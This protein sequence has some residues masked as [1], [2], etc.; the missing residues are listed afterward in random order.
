[1]TDTTPDAGQP[2][3][4]AYMPLDDVPPALDNPKNHD[5]DGLRAS[6]E[7]LG[8]ADAGI[9]DE[10]TGRLIGG[11]GRTEALMEMRSEHR[12]PPEGIT[13]D[14]HGAWLVPIQRGWASRNDAE[15]RALLIAVNRLPEKGGWD[16]AGRARMLEGL[17]AER[18]Q[19]LAAT[20]YA[21]PD[22]DQ[23]LADLA[24]PDAGLS[25]SSAASD[26][27]HHARNGRYEP[28]GWDQDHGSTIRDSRIHNVPPPAPRPTLADRFLIPPF[29]VFDT[30]QDWWQ[31]R[32][33]RWKGLG[34]RS[35]LGRPARD[36][37]AGA[38]YDRDQEQGLAFKSPN[39]RDPTYYQQKSDA[40]AILGR[41]LSNEEFEAAHYVPSNKMPAGTSVFDPVLCELFTRWFTPPGGH[42]LDPFAGG[43]VRGLVAAL[44]GR[45]YTGWDLRQDQVDANE[46][47]AREF[48]ARGLL[49]APHVPRWHQGDSARV[50]GDLEPGTYDAVWTCPPYLWL[51]K[52][53]DDPADLSTMKAD[54]FE[55]AYRLIL[56]GAARALA[57]NRFAGIVVGDVRDPRGG[58]LYDLRGMTIRAA[59]DAGLTY[60]SSATVITHA[61][62]L[63][64]RT[65]RWFEH[66]R[67]LGR[68]TQTLLVFVKGDR[69]AAATACGDVDVTLPDGLT[70]LDT[71]DD[72]NG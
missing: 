27:V 24:R 21:P 13:L 1:M 25:L 43:S 28:D 57:P 23:M 6:F 55:D 7:A 64:V 50:L 37:D 33:G 26:A 19:L 42:L 59:E 65:G 8:Y 36:A 16:H 52:Y 45:R 38:G 4:I 70:S 3:W 2:R 32:K 31:K 30:R 66:G 60:A 34:I 58:R 68:M 10:R 54:Q 22:L 11:H 12:D 35:E 29:D 39:G 46:A 14:E 53:S 47:Q 44:L 9:L 71:P 17:V 72:P 61:G 63:A 49:I 48:A 56:A 69:A 5:L 15:A 51:E 41:E 62:S 67:T 20:G 40:E 18:P